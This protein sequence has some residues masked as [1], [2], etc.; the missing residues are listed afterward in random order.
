[1]THKDS[2]SSFFKL[3]YVNQDYCFNAPEH[4]E[5]K[6]E[7]L[8]SENI[9]TDY[10]SRNYLRIM[11]RTSTPEYPCFDELEKELHEDESQKSFLLRF[12]L[13]KVKITQE[14]REN[15][16]DHLVI[17]FNGLN[18]IDRYDT[19]DKLGAQLADYGIASVLLP[20]P[21]HLNRRIYNPQTKKPKRPTD[22][23]FEEGK[24][25]IFYYNF[26]RTLFEVEDLIERI[27]DTREEDY[28][29]YETFF[30]SSVKFTIFG[31]SLGGLRALGAFLSNPDRYHSC[32][33]LN[34]GAN[35]FRAKIENLKVDTQQWDE[36]VENLSEGVAYH[37]A[38]NDQNKEAISLFELL[39]FT[40]SN[41]KRVNILKRNSNKFLMING[42]S[43][44]I[45]A[46][47]AEKYLTDPQHGLNQIIIAGVDHIPTLDQ[48]WHHWFSHVVDSIRMFMSN[49]DD[50]SIPH[51]RVEEAIFLHLNSIGYIDSLKERF[52]DARACESSVF[53]IND[54]KR[55]VAMLA[56]KNLPKAATDFLKYYYISK[57]Y[58][59]KFPELLAKIVRFDKR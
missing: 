25:L 57:A 43:D 5:E 46:Q 9:F 17:M 23:S 16:I 20:T 40:R 26:R 33:T 30:S 2:T 6:V 28:G 52:Q 31:F 22:I 58:Y 10:D 18:E 45:I 36:M 53:T 15:R 29:F 48:K 41:P 37:I 1:M 19:Y 44:K 59:P 27:K 8:R 14:R 49:C 38:R 3:S 39:Y 55:I 21:Y 34:M 4:S 13:P 56:D 7:S 35:V 11:K 51:E 24:S 32:I 50:D 47:G 42:A 54:L 12:Y